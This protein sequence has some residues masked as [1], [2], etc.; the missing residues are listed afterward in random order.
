MALDVYIQPAPGPP[1]IGGPQQFVCAL[2]DDGYYW[3]LYPRF[4][5]LAEET[6]L[7]ID[8][9]DGVAFS[10]ESLDALART[11]S[12]ARTLVDAQPDE[13][14]IVT[15]IR[16]QPFGEEVRCK[17]V[18]QIMIELLDRLA[19]AIQRAIANGECILFFGD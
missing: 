11:I 15:A 13:W 19:T 18:Q 16:Q 5:S 1:R 10:G 7:W 14:E 6:G 12:A 3:Y 4:V 9:Y 8:L 2:D 17:V